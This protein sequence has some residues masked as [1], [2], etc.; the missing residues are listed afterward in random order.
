LSKFHHK[1]PLIKKLV[2]EHHTWPEVAAFIGHANYNSLKNWANANGIRLTDIGKRR[3]RRN[4]YTASI[5]GEPENRATLG[6]R[7]SSAERLAQ[8]I[9]EGQKLANPGKVKTGEIVRRQH[10][11]APSDHCWPSSS[12]LA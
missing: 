4:G 12:G 9:A 11:S 6:D 5:G 8:L 7:Q 10:L 2:S 1:K 3:A